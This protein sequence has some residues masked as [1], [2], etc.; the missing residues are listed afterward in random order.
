MAKKY[1]FWD[2]QLDTERDLGVE[3]DFGSENEAKE[4]FADYW[5]DITYDEVADD[6]EQQYPEK[7]KA[8]ISGLAT[9]QLQEMTPDEILD[10]WGFEVREI[11][12]NKEV[13]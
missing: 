6:L 7:D 9:K 12:Q 4:Y 8:E 10:F 2:K 5:A 3:N 11:T 1:I 13:K